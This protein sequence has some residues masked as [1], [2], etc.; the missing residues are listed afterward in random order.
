MV[1]R[2]K[3][4]RGCAQVKAMTTDPSI[5][6]H[7]RLR[8]GPLFLFGEQHRK[9]LLLTGEEKRKKFHCIFEMF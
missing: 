8:Q 6:C 1:R 4:A 2:L 3:S 5:T 9:E 7:D